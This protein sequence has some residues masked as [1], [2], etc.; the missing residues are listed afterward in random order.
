MKKTGLFFVCGLISV[1]LLVGIAAA[2]ESV[3][4]FTSLETEEVVEYL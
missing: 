2:K 1:F 3:V 4:V